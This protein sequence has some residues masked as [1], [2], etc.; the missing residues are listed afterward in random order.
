MAAEG[1]SAIAA[2]RDLRGVERYI[3][4]GLAADAI[5]AGRRPGQGPGC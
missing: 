5:P 1:F 3:A 4:G 2:R